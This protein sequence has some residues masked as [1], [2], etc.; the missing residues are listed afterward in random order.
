MLGRRGDSDSGKGAW[1]GFQRLS[2]VYFDQ[3]RVAGRNWVMGW[4]TAT[5]ASPG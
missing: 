5:P 3:E 2:W 4:D 1:L